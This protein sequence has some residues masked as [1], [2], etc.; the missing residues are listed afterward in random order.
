MPHQQGYYNLP[1]FVGENYNETDQLDCLVVFIPQGVAYRQQLLSLMDVACRKYAWFTGTEEQRDARANIWKEAYL[2]T[3]ECLMSDF[4]CQAVMDA[5]VALQAGMDTANANIEQLLDFAQRNE[6][7]LTAQQPAPATQASCDEPRVQSGAIAVVEY[8]NTLIIDLMQIAEAS[9]AGDDLEEYA[10][11]IAGI[12]VFETLPIDDMFTFVDWMFENQQQD[13]EAAITQT[14][15]EEAADLLHCIVMGDNCTLTTRGLTKWFLSL[16]DE[17]PANIAADIFTRFG[18]ATEPSTVNQ[19]NQFLNQFINDRDQGTI[20][21]MYHRL[22]LAYQV[23]I[24][25]ENYSYTSCAGC[26]TTNQPAIPAPDEWVVDEFSHIYA[27]SWMQ[28]SAPHTI[29]IDM[30]STREVTAVRVYWWTQQNP[31]ET[32]LCHV[33]AGDDE[34]VVKTWGGWGVPNVAQ[35]EFSTPQ[36][37]ETI[38]LS[39]PAPILVAVLWVEWD[40]CPI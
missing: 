9:E 27:N 23:G 22:I 17:F 16:R 39:L 40:S 1:R 29:A 38:Y 33:D 2:K 15:I 8:M 28:I 6:G 25:N 32:W 19:A 11:I 5:L 35:V 14:W 20:F 21:D 18:E 36:T 3:L 26:E 31:T 37:G 34:T 10:A 7:A 12:P 30:L 13:F 24:Q 4:N